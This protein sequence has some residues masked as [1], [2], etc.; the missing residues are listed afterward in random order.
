[1]RQS[2]GVPFISLFIHHFG[3]GI[4]VTAHILV[5][6]SVRQLHLQV[7]SIVFYYT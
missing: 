1:M 7:D 4:G 2:L 6:I 5:G 3:S